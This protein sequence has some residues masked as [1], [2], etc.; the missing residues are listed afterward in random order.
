VTRVG[1]F[2]GGDRSWSATRARHSRAARGE[3]GIASAPIAA[4]GHAW[5]TGHRAVRNGTAVMFV[6]V[7]RVAGENGEG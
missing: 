3:G 2:R 5:A 4:V 7:V 6:S 1:D